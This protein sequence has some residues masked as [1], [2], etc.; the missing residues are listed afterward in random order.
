MQGLDA[1]K[2]HLAPKVPALSNLFEKPSSAW[3]F[4]AN[5]QRKGGATFTL[6]TWAESGLPA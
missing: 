5:M 6:N 1:Q 4:R 3:K 2:S